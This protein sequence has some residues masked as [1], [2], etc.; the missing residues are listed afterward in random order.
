MPNHGQSIL[1][2][3]LGNDLLKDDGVGIAAVQKL[4]DVLDISI[5]CVQASTSGLGLMDYLAGR[6]KVIIIDAIVLV[7]EKVGQVFEW[8]LDELST[9]TVFSPHYVGLF[10]IREIARLLTLPFPKELKVLG[11]VVKDPFAIGEKMSPEVEGAIDKVVEM[12]KKIISIWQ[13][14]TEIAFP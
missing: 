1:V 3:G 5:D 4:R 11:I 12:V 10:E 6:D 9:G 2:L 8:H 13:K 7:P 14:E